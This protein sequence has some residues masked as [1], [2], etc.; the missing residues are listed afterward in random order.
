MWFR[1]GRM[2]IIPFRQ[3]PALHLKVFTHHQD[4]KQEE[5]EYY[6]LAYESWKEVWQDVQKNEMNSPLL[7]SYSDDFTRQDHIICLFE[8]KNCIAVAF[9]REI[10]PRLKCLTEDSSFRFWPKE[11]MSFLA[12]TQC[13]IILATSFT[14]TKPYRRGVIEWKT[15]FLGLY[16]D[17][18]STLDAALMVTAARKIKSNQKLCY[19]LGG[20]VLQQDVP[21]TSKAGER[22][23][24][25][26]ADLLCWKKKKV[27]L[28]NKNLQKLREKIW[29]P[30][31]SQRAE[32]KLL[33]A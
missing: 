24:N 9:M 32:L 14:I 22:I 16:L 29:G 6:Q 1:I 28:S 11:L 20:E 15:L 5:E 21:F 4:L 23:E 25:E 31:H 26:I 2:N 30:F 8:N 33:T 13:K 19:Q 17:Y 7:E 3:Q 10:N 27:C 12:E 18:F